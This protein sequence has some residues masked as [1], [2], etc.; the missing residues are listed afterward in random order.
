MIASREEEVYPVG[1]FFDVDRFFVG[2][3]FED[4]LFEVEEGSFVGHFLP[5]LNA[6]SPGVVCV[7]LRTIGTLSVLLDEFY[8][9][10]LLQDC[11][12]EGFLLYGNLHFDSS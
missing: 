4:E 7:A 8:I 3:L 1:N 12:L 11:S 6:G 5:Y 9:E 10:G 2:A